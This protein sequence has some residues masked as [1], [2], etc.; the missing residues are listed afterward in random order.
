MPKK[1]KK[2]EKI[3]EEILEQ[4][5]QNA[6]ASY[7]AK[8]IYV[9]EG[10]EPVRRRPGMYIGSTGVEGL[11]H[12]IW[13]CVD[14]SLTYETPV[15][16]REN[17]K[18]E[19][20]K[21][22]E[23]VD[24]AIEKNGSIIS[25][26]NQAEILRNGFKIETLSFNPQTLKLEWMPV[27]SLIRHRVNSKIL[28]ITL[29]NNRKVQITPY[30]SLFTLNKGEVVPIKGSD[31]KIGIPLV[32]PKVYPEPES[33]LKEINL[34]LEL[35]K[36]PF[37]KT[38]SINFY[39]VK[40]VLTDDV[41][42]F[43]KE[44][45]LAKEIKRSWSNIF[46]DFYRYDYLPFNVWR[47]FPYEIKKRF[48]NCL[49]GNK[50]NDDFK[51]KNILPV[52][53]NLIE[54]LGIYT[55]EGTNLIG[56]CN[57]VIFSFGNQE[58]DLI[59]YVINLIEK[60]FNYKT[61]I[62]YSH[63]TASTIQIDSYIISLIFKEVFKTGCNSY[64]KVVPFIVF[65]VDPH[66]RERYLIAYLAGDG[67]PAS[68]FIKHLIKN[69][70]PSFKPSKKFTAVSVSK[71]LISGL[72]Y[73]LFSLG[74][75]FSIGEAN[76]RQ[77]ELGKVRK[78]KIN[79]HGKVKIKEL[80]PT[81]S[82]KRLDFYWTNEASYINNYPSKEII[83]QINWQRPYSFSINLKGGIRKEKVL[84]L[85]Q[86]ERI[87]L[88]P[89]ALKFLSSDLGILKVKKIEE[90]KYN[91]PWV[92]DLAVPNGEN[93]VGGFAPVVCHNSID[94]AM[95]GYAKN[96]L[97]EILKDNEVAI[98]DDG[99]GIP[100]DIHPKTKKSA[101][102]TVLC[103]LH[104]G[105]KFGGQSY[106][107]A[108]GLHGV[109]VS[110]VNALS[111]HLIA[112]V[113]RDNT[114]YRQ[115]YSRGKPITKVLKSGRCQKSGTKITFQPDPEVFK[116]IKFDIK[117][118]LDHLRQ[119]AY[120]TPKLTIQVKDYREKALIPSY[121]FHFES[122]IKSF[123]EYLARDY[124]W[125]VKNP[126]YVSLEK[127]NILVEIALVYIE[128][129]E[130]LE[131]SFANN[132]HTPEGGMHL[133]GFRAALTRVLNDFAKE[134]EFF[135]GE[136]NGFT[137]EDVR[138]GLVAVVSIKLREPQF[139]GQTKA[140]L[141][142]PEARIAV[143]KTMSESFKEYLE[144][145]K[146]DAKRII[147][148]CLLS[149]RA[150]QAAKKARENILRKGALEGATLPGKLAD[151]IT[152]KASEAELFIVEG[153]SAGGSAKLGRDR[154]FQAILPLRGKILNVEKARFDKMMTSEE[155]KSLIIA[156]GTAIGE[157]FDLDRLRYHKIII[158]SD[159]DSVTYDIPVFIF[160][161]EKQRLKLEKVGDFIE[162]KCQDTSR[163]QIFACDLDK[164]TFS[165]RD[166]EKTI[167]HPLRGDLYEIKTHYGYKIKITSFH[168]VFI[169]R[170]KNFI[171]VPTTELKIG[172]R[173]IF[174]LS[175]PRLDQRI[176]IDLR[177]LLAKKVKDIQIKIPALQM[178]LVSNDRWFDIS[179]NNWLRPQLKSQEQKIS[180][181]I[182]NK[183][184]LGSV[185]GVSFP[186]F[187]NSSVYVPL[188]SLVNTGLN[189]INKY[190]FQNHY[191]KLKVIFDLDE[192]LAYLLGFYLGKG[193]F[194]PNKKNPNHFVLALEN[195]KEFDS[196]NLI[197]AI[198]NVLKTKAVINKQ[199]DNKS[200]LI[201]NSYE[202]K[203]ILQSLN[204]LDKKSFEKFVPEEI[205]NVE[206]KIQ[207]AFLRGYLESSGKIIVKSY[208]GK[209]EIKLTFKTNSEYLSEGIV[210]LFRQLGIFPE[211]KK[212]FS[213]D[214]QNKEGLI[215]NN[216]YPAAIISVREIDQLI[217]IKD[218]WKNHKKSKELE[219]HLNSSNKKKSGD[220]KV[221]I[222]ETV[223]LPI[224]SI[225]KVRTRDYF[226]YDFAIKKDENFVA[227]DGGFLLHN[228]DGAHIRTLLLTLFFR[229]FRPVIEKGYL[230]IAQPPLYRIQKGKEVLYAYTEEEKDNLL[231]KILK[232]KEEKK[233]KVYKLKLVKEN[234]EG[235]EFKVESKEEVEEKEE[236]EEKISGIN[237]QRYKGLG[238]M[239]PDQ[240]WETTMDPSKRV[241]KKV[242]IEDAEEA[243]KLFDIL[244]GEEVLPR[245]T[246][247]QAYA[248]KVKNLDI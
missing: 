244:M 15:F 97:V 223:L 45:C 127:D 11:H 46:Y 195:D 181:E 162:N 171:T 210:L 163:Y 55:A 179:F 206:P 123:I 62:H 137:G 101:L 184:R 248:Q 233:E 58:K 239:N 10:L 217:K 99:R 51:I 175:M 219:I 148:K 168:N 135:K 128:D 143:E 106:K 70:T 193:Y 130:T 202:F 69:T 138:E 93:F 27:F 53:K 4:N 146:E 88:Y 16:I 214:F 80:L 31:I 186:L 28:E 200:E 83:S 141:G 215:K 77:N 241:L 231:R 139:E 34:A 24:K 33:Y 236:K 17:G 61:N 196:L 124:K 160:D 172:D 145:N 64:E 205:F 21:I 81:H 90:V 110:V 164:K 119:Q 140:K 56:K 113:C 185:I 76:S 169:Y 136:E 222:G 105:G 87:V 190:Y 3:K 13:E 100:V 40:S 78:I 14:N 225:K 204:L 187:K 235:A 178:N 2:Q 180:Q 65:N 232:T 176:K 26:Q 194:A 192:D 126:F 151:C 242:T 38:N 89:L 167:R 157:D 152:K 94:E 92:Y 22:G 125:L 208:K 43:V 191:R 246:F 177:P 149:S 134:N 95:A 237:I 96:I 129:Q 228:T 68:E 226:V 188:S 20:E 224:T 18:I 209:K 120:L 8:D 73:L 198:N 102:E 207:K 47:H 42:V 247:I 7:T 66:L 39:N 199:A 229:Y 82:F 213:K 29:E 221:Q 201:F 12:L 23:I 71:E 1:I 153:E 118:I 170:D 109:G 44:Y 216:N 19:L 158:M 32:V 48:F 72:S 36:L 155:I 212:R 60:V 230:Y 91:H 159:A 197:K 115:E 86:K 111:E 132:I 220:K 122:G 116:E 182:I 49:I 5:N 107:V 150:R 75:T 25:N 211:I 189:N 67:Y 41:K 161:K 54:L 84:S 103:T 245:K 37:E 154:N 156:L 50:R 147:E 52:D 218:I 74:K 57:R 121:V 6:S 166:I 142:N 174:P 238:E 165:L 63:E 173:I 108:G 144:I 30:H 133:T 227:G 240:L 243:D 114:L 85:C 9:L 117:K 183:E 79:Y 59:N 104:A 112:E 234:E 131:L 35:E 203:L 98:T